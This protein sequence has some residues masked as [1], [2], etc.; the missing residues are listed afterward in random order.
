MG[1]AMYGNVWRPMGFSRCFLVIWR[2]DVWRCMATY[3]DQ[4]VGVPR[5]EWRVVYSV[6]K[7]GEYGVR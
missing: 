5:N 7:E 2:G 3:G 6:A 4:W 1:V